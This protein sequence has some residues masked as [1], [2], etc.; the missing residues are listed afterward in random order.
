[1][2]GYFFRKNGV[3]THRVAMPQTMTSWGLIYRFLK[4]KLSTEEY[5]SG[6][7]LQDISNASDGKVVAR[8]T[9]GKTVRGDLVGADGSLSKVRQTLLP[10]IKPEHSGYIAWRGLV[11]ESEIPRST[12]FKLANKFSFALSDGGHWLGYLVAGP[13]DDLR[14]GKKMV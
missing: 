7:C 13:N 5:H 4:L 8:F 10:H 14:Q 9:N 3:V 2:K 6:H 11:N 12:L 1:M